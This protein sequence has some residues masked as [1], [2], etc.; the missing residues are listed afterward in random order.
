MTVATNNT[1]N[2]TQ[3][4]ETGNRV[5]ERIGQFVIDC[6]L[7]DQF[8]SVSHA[9]P[10]P[11]GEGG[12]GKAELNVKPI[13]VFPSVDANDKVIISNLCAMR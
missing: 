12:R 4:I 5:L 1:F 3:S 2:T 11:W 13:G 7:S 9:A 8:G 10:K 6:L